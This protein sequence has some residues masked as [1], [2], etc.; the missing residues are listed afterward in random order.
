MNLF[1]PSDP[2]PVHFV[3]IAGAGMSALAAVAL[4]R[5]VRVTGS[6]RSPDGA[7]DL[8]RQ[9]AEVLHGH[10]PEVVA[11]ARAVVVSAAVPEDDPEVRRAREL[12]IP[13]VPRKRA[14]ALLVA[15]GRTVAVAGTH[16]KTTTTA[17][18]TEALAAAGFDPTGL[19]GGRVASWGGNARHGSDAVFVVEADEYDQAFLELRPEVAVV[20]NVEPDHL[21]CYEGSVPRLESAFAEFAVRASTVVAGNADEGTE[22]V[23]QLVAARFAEAGTGRVWRFGP[24][25]G[26]L[27]IVTMTAAAPGS[28]AQVR[29]PGGDVA[30]LSLPVPGEH[31]IRNAVGALGAVLAM[32]GAVEP[33]LEALAAFQ[34]VGRRFEWRGETGGVVVVDDYAHHATEVAATLAAARQAYP[35]H[36]LVAVFQPHLYSRTAAQAEPLGR[37]LAAADLVFVTEIY[38]A[39]EA[40]IPGVT[41]TLV[42]ERAREAGAATRF[43]GSRSELVADVASAV[44]PGDLVLTL[45]AGDIT[46]FGPELLARMGA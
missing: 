30:N 36:R 29:L 22:R 20:T 32:G 42:A 44:R 12:A 25:A 10:H 3:G 7:P 46:S 37:A 14:L 43:A 11:S 13:V 31:N 34:G 9:G 41:G 17:M 6:D 38:P 26:D 28:R 39:R 23:A 21:E 33:A 24:G 5:G 16:G 2:R 4:R 35:G 18:A 15:G 45:G 1:L 27:D 19:A 8:T 40:P